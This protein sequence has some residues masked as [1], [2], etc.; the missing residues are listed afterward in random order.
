MKLFLAVQLAGAR[1]SYNLTPGSGSLSESTFSHPVLALCYDVFSPGF[2]FV[3]LS[4]FGF[5]G[6]AFI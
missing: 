6:E 5:T 4:N 2:N 1:Q 3:V